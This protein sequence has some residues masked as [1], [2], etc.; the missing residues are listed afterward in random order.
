MV[1][2]RA[3]APFFESGRPGSL[4]LQEPKHLNVNWRRCVEYKFK[5]MIGD[6]KGTAVMKTSALEGVANMVKAREPQDFHVGSGVRWPLMRL[7]H[8]YD[9]TLE[10]QHVKI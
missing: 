9:P 3:G 2:T 5:G 10:G 4:A 6:V 8:H 1:A 7:M